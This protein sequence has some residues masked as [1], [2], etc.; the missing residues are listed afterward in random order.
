[1]TN[2]TVDSA[3]ED[4]I[5]RFLLQDRE[6]CPQCSS[7]AIEVGTTAD[8][9]KAVRWAACPDCRF[10]LVTD[11]AIMLRDAPDWLRDEYTATHPSF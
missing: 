2:S 3:L 11:D 6:R 7:D 4:A 5:R 10:Y 8:Y 9:R 1:M